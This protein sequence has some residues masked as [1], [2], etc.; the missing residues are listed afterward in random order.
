MR[1]PCP[2]RPP[3]FDAHDRG[4]TYEWPSMT[5]TLTYF[6]RLV[7]KLIKCIYAKPS[8]L[9]QYIVTSQHRSTHLYPTTRSQFGQRPCL[10]LQHTT[11]HRKVIHNSVRGNHGRAQP[12][13]RHRQRASPGTTFTMTRATPLL[14]TQGEGL[15]S[16]A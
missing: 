6:T 7:S 13:T 15:C 9:P 5:A 10:F 4:I 1:G 16:N 12:N 2:P 3:A 14:F 8:R 11:Y